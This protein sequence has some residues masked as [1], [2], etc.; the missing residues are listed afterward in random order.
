MGY[1]ELTGVD[2]C[3]G[4]RRQFWSETD[5][6]VL[7][8]LEEGSGKDLSRAWATTWAGLGQRLG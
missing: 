7:T 4:I 1:A 3:T 5:V 2:E 6:G 8:G